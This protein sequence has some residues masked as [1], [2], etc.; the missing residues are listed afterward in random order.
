MD[1]SSI[2]TRFPIPWANSAG[3][4]FIRTIPTNSQIPI[5]A[6][7]ASL[8][9]GFPPD[10]FTP[11]GAGGTPPFGQDFNGI[12]N[13][14]TKWLIWYQGGAPVGY[15]ATFST[16][17]DGYAAGAIL[18]SNSVLGRFWFS[19]VDNNTTNPDSGG[20]NWIPF[21]PA[22]GAGGARIISSNADASLLVT[23]TLIGFNRT[24]PPANQ[25]ISLLAKGVGQ[26][27]KLFDLNATVNPSH[28][29]TFFP[30][31]GQTFAG[32][33]SYVLAT[34]RGSVG[35]TYMGSNLWG[36]G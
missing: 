19:T 21:Y 6:G 36:I 16:G 31:G 15:D 26:G 2:P 32:A 5:Q 9:D 17:Q 24:S 18:A 8:T 29:I 23:D 35:F 13:E 3:P 14:I 30:P 11:V 28:T 20:A 10:C 25:Q 12:L 34:S 27:V 33:S 7:A 4:S 1:D 22:G